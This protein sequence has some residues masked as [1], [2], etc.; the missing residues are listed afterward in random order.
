MPQKI[1]HNWSQNCHLVSN[2]EA[3]KCAEKKGVS[4]LNL[5]GWKHY[6]TS[7][8]GDVD[9]CPH[10]CIKNHG[11]IKKECIFCDYK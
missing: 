9:I 6:S 11:S 4:C 1:C 5:E 7:P 2:E 3:K 10:G 8:Y